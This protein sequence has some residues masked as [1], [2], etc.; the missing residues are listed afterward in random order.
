LGESI[1]RLSRPEILGIA[2]GFGA[3]ALLL[4]LFM[5][6]GGRHSGDATLVMTSS[7]IA[8]ARKPYTAPRDETADNVQTALAQS[9]PEE[10][11]PA[12]ATQSHQPN[13]SVS[14]QVL[15][16]QALSPAATQL[17]TVQ[18][19]PSSAILPAVAS[20]L[21][22]PPIQ[23]PAIGTTMP[24]NGSA[25]TTMTMSNVAAQTTVP[26][27]VT[28]PVVTGP[29]QPR[30]R[31]ASDGNAIDTAN[32]PMTTSSPT[33]NASAVPSVPAPL[34]KPMASAAVQSTAQA[35]APQADKTVSAASAPM[36]VVVHYQSKTRAY[37]AAKLLVAKLQKAGIDASLFGVKSA[38]ASDRIE[39]Y[40]NE[41][42]DGAAKIK[43][44]TANTKDSQGK[45]RSFSVVDHGNSSDAPALGSINVWLHI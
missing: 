5:A 10:Y 24:T 20:K 22:S 23:P 17:Q 30:P 25:S 11:A 13:Q 12:P 38:I 6:V 32:A 18:T 37:G 39:F 43:S 41:D 44:M 29:A 14:S 42:S 34:Q 15:P 26:A 35:S 31:P 28:A 9:P 8:A 21:P 27:P 36:H 45:A 4:I 40:H 1:S 16:A 19:P 33:I 2:G 7:E 3:S